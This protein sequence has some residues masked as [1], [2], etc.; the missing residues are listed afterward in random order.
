MVIVNSKS[1]AFGRTTIEGM[2][3]NCLVLASDTGGTKEIIDDGENGL[4]FKYNDFESFKKKIEFVISHA[5]ECENISLN[6]Y[7]KATEAFN[8]LSNA[9]NIVNIYKSILKE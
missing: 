6:G 4:L 1:E 9:Q 3:N 5:D 2:M 8:S 7:K